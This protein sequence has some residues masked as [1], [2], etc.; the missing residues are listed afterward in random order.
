MPPCLQFVSRFSYRPKPILILVIAHPIN[1]IIQTPASSTISLESSSLSQRGTYNVTVHQR[2]R[3][4]STEFPHANRDLSNNEHGELQ[5]V[6]DSRILRLRSDP[7]VASL[8]ELYD[9][10]GRVANDAFA[11]D[12][13][14]LIQEGRAQVRRSGSTLRQL[15]GA[16]CVNNDND[17]SEGDISWAERYLAYVL[18]L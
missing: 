3:H 9:E 15:L 17:N 14:L 5:P 2:R 10:H 12:E 11:N 13:S 4:A 7:S 8:L 1:K 18:Y 16:P 6:E